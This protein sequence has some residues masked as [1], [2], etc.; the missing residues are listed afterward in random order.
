MSSAYEQVSHRDTN[1]FCVRTQIFLKMI[2]IVQ[3]WSIFRAN[4]P[5]LEDFTIRIFCVC[6]RIN[7]MSLFRF[8]AYISAQN[9]TTMMRTIDQNTSTY[10]KGIIQFAID[11]GVS[12]PVRKNFPRLC[13]Y[14]NNPA[15]EDFVIQNHYKEFLRTYAKNFHVS[16]KKLRICANNPVL[17]D[18]VIQ[19]H[20]KEFLRT[21]AKNFHVSIKKLRICANNPALEDFIIQNRYKEFLR[22]YAKNFH[23]S[24]K[25]LRICANNPVLED[26]A[27]R[28]HY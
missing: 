10:P 18:F 4:N 26:F 19:N 7:S 5:K 14:A 2:L 1:V 21:Y 16:F 3:R 11:L 20:Y 22:T 17:V 28:N 6:T 13:I 9:P 24:I 27:I 25:D 12:A 15:L 8:G 23:V